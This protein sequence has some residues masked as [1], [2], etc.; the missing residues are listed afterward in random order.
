MGLRS[1]LSVRLNTSN[2]IIHIETGTFP[3]I[4]SV[5]KRQLKFWSSL[6]VNM[7]MNSSLH[8][9]LQKAKDISLPYIN[10]YENL[11]STY[12]T[13]EKCEKELRNF[14]LN[15]AKQ[16]IQNEYEKDVDSKIGTYIQVNP[17]LSTPSYDDQMFEI[18]RIHITRLRT[19]SHSLFIETGRFSNPK[20]IRELRICRCGKGLQTIRH[21]L[22]GCDIVKNS[23]GINTFNNTFTEVSDFFTWPLFHDYI[24]FISHVLKFEL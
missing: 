14:H 15:V 19:G 21:V 7:E 16:N 8:I 12:D 23:V 9:L 6:N 18:E 5:K 20:V 24:L 13:P 4:C 22:M 11:T 2:D 1:A 17:T 3:A 10:Y